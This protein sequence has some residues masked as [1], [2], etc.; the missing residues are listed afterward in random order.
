M[1][2]M[3]TGMKMNAMAGSLGFRQIASVVGT[4]VAML[5]GTTVA[6]GQTVTAPYVVEIPHPMSLNIGGPNGN[7]AA[8]EQGDVFVPDAS[9]STVWEFPASGS[10]PVA[11]FKAPSFGPQV[12]GV[13]VDFNNNLY[14]TTRYDGNVSSNYSDIFEFPFVNGAYP[15]AYVDTGTAPAHCTAAPTSVCMYGQFLATTGYY[16]Q[17]QAI[18]FDGAGNG[19]LITTYDSRFGTGGKGIYFCNVSCGQ[20]LSNSTLLV[21]SLPTQATSLAVNYAGDVYYSDGKYIWVVYSGTTTPVKFDDLTGGTSGGA[22]GIGFDRA[23]NLYANANQQGSPYADGDFEYPVI[24]GKITA[25]SK[26]LLDTQYGYTGPTVDSHGNVWTANYGQVF[27]YQLFNGNLPATAVGTTSAALKFT[28]L[29]NQS[30]TIASVKAYQGGAAATEF[31]VTADGCSGNSNGS[32][33]TCNFSVT[34]TPSAVGVRKGAVVLKDTNG[35][36]V[37]T[38]V[39]G[40]G[41]GGAVTVDPGTPVA[42]GSG[43]TAPSGIAVDALGDVFVADAA[44][45][46]VSEF[47]G[48]TGTAVLI[49]SG[50]K[51]PTGVALDPTGN[52]FVVD[53]GAGA[54]FEVPY[55]GGAYSTAAPIAVLTGLKSPTDIVIT[56][57][58]DAYI[59]VT[60]SN[61]VLQYPN[62]TR[63]QTSDVAAVLGSGL[64]G[65]TGIAVDLNGNLFI[66]DT[67]NNRVVEYSAASGQTTVGSG[68]NAP[69]GVTVDASGSVLVADQGNGR[70]VR[71]P[72]E[73][74]ALNGTAQV[75][76]SQPVVNPYAVRLDGTGNLY[77][78]DNQLGVAEQLQRTAGTLNFGIENVLTASAPQGIVLSSTGTSSLTLGSPLFAAI[79]PSTGFALSTSGT[80]GCASGTLAAG[81]DCTLSATFDPSTTGLVSLPVSFAIGATNVTNPT[82]TLTGRG[83]NLQAVTVTVALT[84]PATTPVYGQTVVLQATVANAGNGTAVPTGNVVF[85]VDGQ[86]TKAHAL[87]NATYSLSLSGLSG[88]AHTVQVSYGGDFNYASGSSSV[89]NFTISQA[90]VTDVETVTTDASAPYSSAPGDLVA[91]GF[92]ITP[93]VQ[94]VLAGT[95]TISNGTTIL[96]TVNVSPN[97]TPAGTYGGYF[98]TLT[99]PAG[100]YSLTATFSGNANYAGFTTSPVQVYVTPVSYTVSQSG[101]TITSTASN[102]G[103]LTLTVTSYSDFQGG[104]DFTCSGLPANA[105]CLFLPGTATLV[106]AANTYPAQ[107]PVQTVQMQI[108]VDE[109]PVNINSAGLLGGIGLLSGL[110]LMLSYRRNRSLRRVSLICAL[111]IVAALSLGSLSGCGSSGNAFPTPAGSYPITLTSTATPQPAGTEPTQYAVSSIASSATTNQITVSTTS[112]TTIKPGSTITIV[113]ATPAVFNGVYTVTTALECDATYPTCSGTT[114]QTNTFT[115][116][117]TLGNLTGTSAYLRTG[118][119]TNYTVTNTLTLVV[120]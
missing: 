91:L 105:Y 87:S 35:V 29:F 92:T 96:G 119:S 77:V 64:S 25:S 5:V 113:N 24:N 97:T 51:S 115:F 81:Y 68:F 74:G 103:S 38:F 100:V 88:G 102:P 31:A 49:G 54:I 26:F 23:G 7:L 101:G 114:G 107:V 27:E 43:L 84:S 65:P 82:L 40:I 83:V 1:E 55:S 15:G 67:G 17:P 70:I 6:L 52:L 33:G 106:N 22:T 71:I 85:S 116:A 90:T 48:G 14:V 9:H 45:K 36:A 111:A 16:Y 60:G 2:R 50:Y 66:A 99:L 112:L 72:N 73:A 34:F 120:K 12:S 118:N 56:G 28:V 58:G 86:N 78:T 42:I 8:D 95:I 3:M 10:A 39:S 79:N 89:F 47:I 63:A 59:S 4:A 57:I 37:T 75:A 19:Y 104:V 108:V 53:N 30:G 94:G 98:S 62:A 11:I 69:T 117:S 61:E 13:A 32:R 46:T 18:G 80:T 76:I 93:S 44:A 20:N 41:T 21:G 110:G 109:S